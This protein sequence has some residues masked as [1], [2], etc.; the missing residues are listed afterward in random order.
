M[1][2]SNEDYSIGNY[3]LLKA[4]NSTQLEAIAEYKRDIDSLLGSV[5]SL[6]A[7]LDGARAL[8]NG[9]ERGSLLSADD[10]AID[11][12]LEETK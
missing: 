1:N 5:V 12:W 4:Y 3:D 6:R 7:Q 8:F 2:D 10:E 9:I 11:R